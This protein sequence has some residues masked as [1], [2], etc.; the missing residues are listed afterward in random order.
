MAASGILISIGRAVG[1]GTWEEEAVSKQIRNIESAPPLM[2]RGSTPEGQGK[3]SDWGTDLLQ[4]AAGLAP[5]QALARKAL[6]M[7]ELAR[8]RTEPMPWGYDEAS[9]VGELQAGSEAAF[10]LLVTHY[11]G[12]VYSLLYGM[13]ND[14]A[15][16]ADVTQEVFLKAFRGIRSFRG[17][18]SLKTWLYRIAVREALNHRRWSWRHLRQQ[19]SIDAESAGEGGEA[20]RAAM[21]LEDGGPTPFESMASQEMQDVVHRALAQVPSVFRSAVILRDLEGLA[22]EEVAEVLEVSVGT[23]KSRILRGRA[24][25][26]EILEPLWMATREQ[27]TG[28]SQPANFSA[29]S[30]LSGL[31]PDVVHGGGE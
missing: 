17:S 25:L 7:A 30:S 18:S 4:A 26:R 31:R 11:H 10:D 27:H 28:Y 21:Q 24:A 29:M 5:S 23:V 12:P 8:Q 19:F 16:A 15:D 22:Y 20:Q 6:D 14:A 3:W 13:L 9:F 2:E 1:L